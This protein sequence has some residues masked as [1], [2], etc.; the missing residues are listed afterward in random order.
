MLLWKAAIDWTP[1]H[2]QYILLL[3]LLRALIDS[4]NLLP[5]LVVSSSG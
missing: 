3:L 5:L 4:V 1:T 2:P